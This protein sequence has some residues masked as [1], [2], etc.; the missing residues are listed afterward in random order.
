MV[1]RKDFIFTISR[2]H[3]RTHP[4]C[5]GVR[6]DQQI[7]AHLLAQLDCHRKG[8]PFFRVRRLH[9]WKIAIRQFLLLHDVYLRKPDLRQC[10]ANG[11]ISC[12]VQRSEDDH[13]V[14]SRTGCHQFAVN[15]GVRHRLR[16]RLIFGG[17]QPYE[18]PLRFRFLAA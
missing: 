16:K 14:L 12:S 5:I 7:S 15:A 13:E 4:V 17:P 10:A 18:Q 6:A 8:F 2:P 3:D 11:K 1:T 9:R